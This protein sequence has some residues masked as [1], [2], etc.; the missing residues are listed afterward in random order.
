V[1]RGVEWWAEAPLQKVVHMYAV[2]ME[3]F[4][5]IAAALPYLAHP[6]LVL[7]VCMAMCF[8]AYSGRIISPAILGQLAKRDRAVV[9]NKLVDRGFVVVCLVVWVAVWFFSSGG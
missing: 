3:E 7:V 2:S 4:K 1:L 9:L 8:F 6:A 5:L